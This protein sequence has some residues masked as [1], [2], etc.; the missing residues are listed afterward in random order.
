MKPKSLLWNA[1]THITLHS[2]PLFSF[3]VMHR[4]V[5]CSCQ[6]SHSGFATETLYTCLVSP[7]CAIC[8]THFF[9]DLITSVPGE[10]INHEADNCAFFFSLLLFSL[11]TKYSHHPYSQ[12]LA[13]LISEDTLCIYPHFPKF[14]H[15]A[16]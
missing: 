5:P 4:F 3:N 9:L 6:Q 11:G 1:Q 13:M 2:F 8:L 15:F 12:T 16:Y 14:I 7:M 10:S